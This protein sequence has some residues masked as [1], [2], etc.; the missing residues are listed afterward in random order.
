MPFPGKVKTSGSSEDVLQTFSD[1]ESSPEMTSHRQKYLRHWHQPVR[2]CIV[3][4]VNLRHLP[5]KPT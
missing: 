3:S 5:R 4:I 2:P 1:N